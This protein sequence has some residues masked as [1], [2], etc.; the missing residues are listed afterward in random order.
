MKSRTQ[1]V[2]LKVCGITSL[3]DAQAALSVG[4]D[5]LGFNFY[6]KSPRF[7]ALERARSII[8]KLE[9]QATTVGI[10]VNEPG[11]DEVL[12]KA[13]TSGVE[14]IQLHGDEDARFCEQVGPDRVIK[15]LRVGNDFDPQQVVDVPARA[16]LLD[17]FD[18]EL[19]GGTGLTAN[20]KIAAKA[21][22][23][24]TVILAGGLGP[25]NIASAIREV[26]PY[27]VD[28]NSGVE[29]SPGR[30]DIGKLQSLRLEMDK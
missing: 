25:E 8:E 15:A 23:L 3:E 14:M 19:Y 9:G 7:I 24:A 16:I 30:K 20:W 26:Q 18:K 6:S 10:F 21:A 4:A 11:P 22:Q 5:F 2:R 17:A 27:A 13:Q 1:K 28:V 12:K 29:I